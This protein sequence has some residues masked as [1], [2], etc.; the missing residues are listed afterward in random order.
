MKKTILIEKDGEHIQRELINEEIEY[1]E[2]EEDQ[3]GLIESE[4]W[5]EENMG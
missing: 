3:E 1:E 2:Y 4:E 5:W